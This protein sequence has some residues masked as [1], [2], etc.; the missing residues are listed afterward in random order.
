MRSLWTW[1]AEGVK[2]FDVFDISLIK[3]SVM[4]VTLLIAKWCPSLLSLDWYW[5]AGVCV[6]A[7]IRPWMAMFR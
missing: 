2:R 4:A 1:M 3:I 7:A 5:Y 6:I